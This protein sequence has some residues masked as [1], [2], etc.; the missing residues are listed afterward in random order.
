M[1]IID[2]PDDILLGE[3]PQHRAQK[4]RAAETVY[5]GQAKDEMRH[6]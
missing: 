2:D 1:L 3:Q 4:A 6:P 5:P